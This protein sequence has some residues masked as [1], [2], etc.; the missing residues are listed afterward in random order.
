MAPT[1]PERKTTINKGGKAAVTPASI[2]VV[3]EDSINITDKDIAFEEDLLRNPY[4]LRHWMRYLDHHESSPIAQRFIVY[5]RAVKE[6]PG[7]YKLW[8]AYLDQRKQHL[9][10]RGL[11]FVKAQDE[12]ES[13]DDCYERAL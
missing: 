8:K 4:S 10:K 13:V 9:I 12:W 7:S 5:E 1:M 2:D 6:L 3:L 11:P